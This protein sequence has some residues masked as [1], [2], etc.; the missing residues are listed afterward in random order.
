MD[1]HESFEETMIRVGDLVRIAERKNKIYYARDWKRTNNLW[2]V[3]EVGIYNKLNPS[4]EIALIHNGQQK[5]HMPQELLEKLW[6]K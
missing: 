6:S 2:T 3:L 1:Q 5:Q 4:E